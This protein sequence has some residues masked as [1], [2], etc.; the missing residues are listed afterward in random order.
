MLR[1]HATILLCAVLAAC[2]PATAS[3]QTIGRAG[4]VVEF[5]L[6]RVAS[7][8]TEDVVVEVPVRLR[9]IGVGGTIEHVVFTDMRLNGIPF[10]VENY[11]TQF[12][13]PAD[14]PVDL[15][16]PLRLRANFA[17]VA[18]GV[19][20]EAIMPSDTL[21][22]TGRVLVAGTFRKWVFSFHRTAEMRIDETGPNP[23]AEYHP[24]RVVLEHLQDLDK[25]G[26]HLPF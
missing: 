17:N 21:N 13:L 5:G 25:L 7:V 24:L 8:S 9:P 1:L 3:A 12:D 20:G 18:P 16:Q 26:I 4:D 14:A 22:L 23:L 15:P 10:E 19:L 11:D 2:A 6:P